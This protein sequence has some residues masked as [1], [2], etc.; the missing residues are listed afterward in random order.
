MSTQ[1]QPLTGVLPFPPSSPFVGAARSEATHKHQNKNC[2]PLHFTK[3]VFCSF[4]LFFPLRAHN[5]REK[6]PNYENLVG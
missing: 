5:A 1:P 2:K 4:L 3:A 6:R